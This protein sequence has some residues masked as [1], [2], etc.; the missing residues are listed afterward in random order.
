MILKCLYQ[1][2]YI[3]LKIHIL[4]T[5]ICIFR[6]LVQHLPQCSGQSRVVTWHIPSD[7]S[8]E[9]SKPSNVVCSCKHAGYIQK[10]FLGTTWSNSQE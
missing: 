7:H 8:Q 1:G 6:V 4:K 2:E 9:M 5:Y 3:L 10:Y